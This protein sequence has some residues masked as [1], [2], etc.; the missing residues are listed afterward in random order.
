MSDISD[1]HSEL[2]EYGVWVK[3]PSSTNTEKESPAPAAEEPTVDAS[4]IT[5]AAATD[6]EIEQ[7]LADFDIDSLDTPVIEEPVIEET[8]VSE[9]LLSESIPSDD[10]TTETVVEESILEEPATEEEPQVTDD[11]L[12][13]DDF[14]LDSL[15]DETG[16]MTFEQDPPTENE[17]SV[18]EETTETAASEGQSEEVS[19]EDGEIDLDAFMSDDSPAPSSDSTPDGDVDLSAFMSDDSAPGQDGE[20]DLSA[21]MGDG[22]D[23][24]DFGNG[25]IDLEAFMGSEGFAADKQEQEEIED[26]DPLDIDL[27]FEDND[28]IE[29][30]D[31]EASGDVSGIEDSTSSFTGMS[32]TTEIEDFDALFD[33]IVDETPQEKKV[34]ATPAPKAEMP[35]NTE[36]INLSDFGFDDDSD[37]QNPILGDGK[38]E[39][40]KQ[41]PVDY[42]MNVDDDDAPSSTTTVEEE[43]AEEKEEDDSDFDIDITQDDEASV[44]K[45][46]ETDLS[47]PDDSFDIDSILNSVEDENGGTV[48][49][50]E[51]KTPAIE[52]ENIPAPSEEVTDSEPMFQE[53]QES[54]F[55]EIAE[56]SEMISNFDEP[57]VIEEPDAS[58]DDE[59]S[60]SDFSIDDFV[61]DEPAAE[62]PE[63]SVPVEEPATEEPV[64]E[65]PPVLEDSEA[66]IDLEDF[67]GEEG[68]TDGGPGVQGYDTVA[69][70]TASE[71]E[72]ATE[73]SDF[74]EPVVEETSI[75]ETATEEPVIEDSTIQEP[76]FDEPVI[77]ES[78]MENS[79]E[80]SYNE[81]EALDENISL[82][83]F[84]GE[85]GF[86]DGGPGVQGYDTVAPAATSQETTEEPELAEENNGSDF[87]ESE[88]SD[89]MDTIETPDF[90][91]EPIMEEPVLSDQEKENEPMS[92]VTEDISTNEGEPDYSNISAFADKKPEYDMTGVTLTLDDFANIKEYPEEPSMDTIAESSVIDEPVIEETSISES[93]VIQD[94]PETYS[95]FIKTESS[96]GQAENAGAVSGENDISTSTDETVADEAAVSTEETMDAFD[97]SSVLSQISEEL[98]SLR[99]EIKGLKSEF[100]EIKKN[101][102]QSESSID[103]PLYGE[104]SEAAEDT[105]ESVEL[106]EPSEDT[107]FFNDTDEDDT[108]A[109]SGDELSNILSTAEFTSQTGESLDDGLKMDFDNDEALEEPVFDDSEIAISE[110]ESEEG[111]IS[112]PTVDDVLV[113]S[114]STDLMD[115]TITTAEDSDEE[116]SEIT[117]D[118]IPS[119]TLESLDIPPYEQEEELTDDNIEFLKEGNDVEEEEEL[120]TGI[121]EQPVEDVFNNWDA[122]SESEIEEPVIEEPVIEETSV[123]DSEVESTGDSNEI[124][125]SMKEEIKSVLSYMD[126]LLENLPEDKIA[127]FAQSE[128]FET[129]KKLFTELGLS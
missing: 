16:P 12:S 76:V 79:E 2:D 39:P 93:E 78:I 38:E 41:G 43:K 67:M 58:N 106:P 72:E 6:L 19:F 98:A 89:T 113:E 55:G 69:Q 51:E 103:S 92:D 23:A 4:F 97:S 90:T 124:P 3:K 91:S 35:G 24:P 96:S 95:V 99:S 118:D 22:G 1:K 121:S 11:E 53:P 56:E 105:V 47:S 129:Y 52:E 73:D 57:T 111:E 54:D 36:E 122:A 49:F 70:D 87:E 33:D 45:E 112:V 20:V 18:P 86:T 62:E 40:K 9:D 74:E 27:D 48:S 115:N 32:D 21:F 110:E 119:P 34:E 61:T 26:A 66:S 102:I 109:L 128:Q 100:E 42:E 31:T 107:G 29:L 17:E 125:A 116:L 60:V 46:Q 68:F 114:S 81:T 77:E 101:G 44:Q 13:L 5:Q 7:D 85:E 75:E 28:N 120:E 50:E 30:Q 80:M 83:D 15:N 126:Q 65:E 82:D 104:E 94:E 108:I 37:N 123:S 63:I 14:S 71:T 10:F 64:I 127:E 59:T 84:M 25:D 8:A 117:D 88:N